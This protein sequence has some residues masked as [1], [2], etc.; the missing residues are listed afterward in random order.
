[1]K[2][3]KPIIDRLL[4]GK[5]ILTNW[6]SF[7]FVIHF[8]VEATVDFSA[9]VNG[10]EL[11]EEQYR[12]LAALQYLVC[13]DYSESEL[14]QFMDEIP[15]WFENEG[16]L[17]GAGHIHNHGDIYMPPEGE[18]TVLTQYVFVVVNI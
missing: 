1:M 12:C 17:H 15:S 5:N 14:D 4:Q 7:V 6:R 18:E 9:H 8:W 16:D 13:S 2:Q 3:L 10:N 11:T